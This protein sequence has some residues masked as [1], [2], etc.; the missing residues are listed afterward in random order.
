M[1]EGR[2]INPRDLPVVFVYASTLCGTCL[3]R[4]KKSW[5]ELFVTVSQEALAVY[6]QVQSWRVR[7]TPQFYV[8]FC[9]T[10]VTQC[11]GVK[12]RV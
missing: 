5:K 9:S 8:S 1:S 4:E 6:D 7:E 10:M 11:R 12:I 3:V 2:R